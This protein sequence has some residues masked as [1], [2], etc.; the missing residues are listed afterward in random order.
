MITNHKSE[1]SS[2]IDRNIFYNNVYFEGFRWILL[3]N[4]YFNTPF[5]LGTAHFINYQYSQSCL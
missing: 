4:S 2:L 3:S 5:L 1:V